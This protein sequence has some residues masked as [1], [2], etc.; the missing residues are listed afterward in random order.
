VGYA[1]QPGQTINID[2][3]FVPTQHPSEEKLPAVSGSSGHLVIERLPAA[4][5]QPHW[6]GQVFAQTDLDYTE[7]MQAYVAATPDRPK[8]AHSGK[9]TP[10]EEPPSIWRQD[11][12]NRAEWHVILQPRKQEDALW[13]AIRQHHHLLVVAYRHL[14]Q[15][16]RK[17]HRGAWETEL[18]LWQQQK[19]EHK[20]LLEK[21]RQENEAWH[22]R[23]RSEARS[24]IAILVVTDNCT[25]Q[26]LALPAFST[27]ARLSSSEL[28]AALKIILPE[29][30]QF[31]IS[32]QGLHFRS[33]VFA[34]LARDADFVHVLI[35]RHRPQSNGIAERFV[36]TLK[37][38]LRDKSWSVP[39]E[40]EPLLLQFQP[41]YNDRPHQGLAIPGLSP[42]E[43][44]NR[45]WLM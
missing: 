28:V 41:E 31:V 37:V 19:Q 38:W 26:C 24:W 27:G 18:H 39:A 42:N 33:N 10:T 1:Q 3:C 20:T 7:A 23:H 2:V 30:L 12:E 14:S 45:I 34:E 22:Q 40:L 25:R 16:R 6:P 32:D 29:G 43:L 13:R 15:V 5:E 8:R 9:R 4:G 11:W 35:Y 21:R 44:A 36:Q 17:Q